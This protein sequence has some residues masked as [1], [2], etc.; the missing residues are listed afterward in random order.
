VKERQRRSSS[1]KVCGNTQHNKE[2]KLTTSK[3]KTKQNKREHKR[4]TKRKKEKRK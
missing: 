4:E 2:L 3:T 1:L